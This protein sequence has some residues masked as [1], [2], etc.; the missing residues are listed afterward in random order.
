MKTMFEGRLSPSCEQL[1]GYQEMFL[2]FIQHGMKVQRPKEQLVGPCNIDL[3]KDFLPVST[4][5]W[6]YVRKIIREANQLMMPFLKLMGVTSRQLSPF[7]KELTTI[8]ELK[9]AY[10]MYFPRTFT[11]DDFVGMEDE[12]EMEPVENDGGEQAR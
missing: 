5:L 7:C 3:Q 11:Y 1:K 10:L 4:Q 8:I 2:N 6:P 12:E 9:E